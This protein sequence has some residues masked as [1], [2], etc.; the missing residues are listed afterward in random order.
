MTKEKIRHGAETRLGLPVAEAQGRAVRIARCHDQRGQR[1]FAATARPF[2]MKEQ[3][4]QRRGRQHEADARRVRGKQIGQ[5]VAA[6]IRRFPGADDDGAARRTKKLGRA[7]ADHGHAPCRVQIRSHD[8]KSL[9]RTRLAA[10][11]LGHGVGVSR[12]ADQMKA[13]E[14]AHGG[15][16]ALPERGQ[17]KK[18][19]GVAHDDVLRQAVALLSLGV[20]GLVRVI[21]RR[22]P[23]KK[24]A[25][26]RAPR[27]ETT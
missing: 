14:S 1:V 11:K 26:R 3:M 7:F 22:A 12:V 4:M 5:R 8:G 24:S 25:R 27:G 23:G 16:P 9:V 19:G 18:H 15:N 13:A 21:E 10:A 6:F 2:G 20:Q 17:Q